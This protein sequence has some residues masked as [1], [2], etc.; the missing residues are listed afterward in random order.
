MSRKYEPSEY[1][2]TGPRRAAS[3]AKR[4]LPPATFPAVMRAC[5][6]LPLHASLSCSLCLSLSSPP[7]L[8]R[9][10]SPYLNPELSVDELVSTIAPGLVEKPVA[11]KGRCYQ[12]ITHGPSIPKNQWMGV[13]VL[14]FFFRITLEPGVA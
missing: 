8:F 10:P 2:R 4:A 13:W 3:R 1:H 12:H 7:S 5:A 9:S 6:S 14:F 11:R